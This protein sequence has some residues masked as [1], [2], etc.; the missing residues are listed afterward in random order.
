MSKRAKI[1]IGAAAV[2][3]LFAAITVLN[4]SSKPQPRPTVPPAQVQSLTPQGLFKD[5][6]QYR[7][8]KGLEPMAY[9]ERLAE[10]SREKCADMAANNYFAHT[11]ADKPFQYFIVRNIPEGSW[12]KLGENLAAGLDNDEAVTNSW[13]TSTEG[14]REAMEYPY[15]AVGFGICKYPEPQASVSGRS[16]SLGQQ[17][18]TGLREGEELPS[19][20][21]VVESFAQFK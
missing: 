19:R 20:T 11:F 3:L 2:M 18:P 13:I 12:I 21:I 6:N 10:A 7:A 17:R 8:T 15:T 4:L 9:D 14:H 5:L 16:I 1:A